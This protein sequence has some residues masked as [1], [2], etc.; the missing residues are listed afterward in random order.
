MTKRS[1]GIGL[2]ITLAVIVLGGALILPAVYAQTATPAPTVT[3]VGGTQT[4]TPSDTE[5]AASPTVTGTLAVTSTATPIPSLTPSPSRTAIPTTPPVTPTTPPITPGPDTGTP[6]TVTVNGVGRADATPDQALVRLGVQ[7]EAETAS[8]ALAQNNAQ[9]T[10]L[11]EALVEAGVAREDIRTQNLVLFPRYEQAPD[12]PTSVL[13]GY[14]AINTVEVRV[15]DLENLGQLLDTAVEAG[16]NTIEGVEFRVSE[17]SEQVVEA[18]AAAVA[19]AQQKAEQ[20]ARL[21]NA[22]LGEV[23]TIT[24]FSN[25]GPIPLTSE[26]LGA[27]GQVPVQPGTQSVEVIVQVTWRLR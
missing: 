10:E 20:L 9:M 13:V 12:S 2:L 1:I 24:E 22:Q 8:E 5:P 7:T 3:P 23:L 18:R 4:A 16:A 19:D 11:L 14:T 21:V 27:G 6:R 17:A 25:Q 15:R 26:G